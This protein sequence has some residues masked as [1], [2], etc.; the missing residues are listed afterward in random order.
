MR[1][2]VGATVGDAGGAVR[3]TVGRTLGP[4][5]RATV[6]P[7]VRTGAL[8]PRRIG[9]WLNRVLGGE[10][11]ALDAIGRPERDGYEA[12]VKNASKP[13]EELSA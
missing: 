2:A 4:A 13:T 10:R 8:V 7:A 5:V 6:G 12:R 1:A 9:E 3:A 11:A